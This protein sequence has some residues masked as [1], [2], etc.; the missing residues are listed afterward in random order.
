[1]RKHRAAREKKRRA[2]QTEIADFPQF[3]GRGVH[4]QMMDV[5]ARW[6]GTEEHAAA[7]GVKAARDKASDAGV[8]SGAKR[9]EEP[10]PAPSL[11][12]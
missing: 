11:N 12:L 8:A 3:G 5:L 7:L 9:R 1:M 10:T 6:P 2:A 4:E